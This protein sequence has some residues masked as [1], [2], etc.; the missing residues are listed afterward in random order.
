MV[1]KPPLPKSR[2]PPDWD[3]S[4]TQGP[5]PSR[6]TLVGS[7]IAEKYR[8]GSILGKGG[9][10]T[11]YEA[12][13]LV[14]G[15]H[16]A[17]KI[18]NPFHANNATAVKRFEQEARAAGTIGHPN[19]CEVFDFGALP[20]GSPYIVMELLRGETLATR[21]K[22]FGPLPLRDVDI[23]IQVIRGLEAAHKHG[24]LHRDIKPENVFIAYG[25]GE[26]VVV[27]LLDFGV[28]KFMVGSEWEEASFTKTGVVMGTP[29]YF[30]PEQARGLR[31]LDARVDVYACGV[32]LY[33]ALTGQRPY[34]ATNYNALLVSIL[35]GNPTMPRA[36]RPSIPV[37]LERIILNAMARNRDERYASATDL[38]G[39]L[40]VACD[41]LPV[42]K[43]GEDVVTTASVEIPIYVTG[44]IE[45]AA[46]LRD[47]GPDDT[48]PN[49]VSEIAT[50]SESDE[51]GRNPR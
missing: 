16:V 8:I 25:A 30:A 17:I 37:E 39:E 46:T 32:L 19:L 14:L 42:E 34:D 23:V 48:S 13:H 2:R 20:D 43:P 49:A 40:V 1:A 21:I 29:C 6:R 9:M 31:D 45:A 47:L 44:T 4:T 24:I 27:K 36:L 15:R 11:V 51:R 41:R 18:L 38:A 12:E 35:K 5:P 50:A 26:T 10:G 3:E 22:R 7:T 28:S 33:E